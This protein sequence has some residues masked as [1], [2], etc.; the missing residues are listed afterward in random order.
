MIRYRRTSL[1][2]SYVLLQQCLLSIN[3]AIS[4]SVSLDHL[5]AL[6][7]ISHNRFFCTVEGFVHTALDQ[8][9][10]IA[11]TASFSTLNDLIEMV[12]SDNDRRQLAM[13]DTGIDI[14][15]S[16]DVSAHLLN[17]GG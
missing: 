7:A 12:Q 3:R 13:N 16:L 1:K 5:R 14:R 2:K 10:F 15:R 4:P 6:C 17:V 11:I 9:A 8:Y